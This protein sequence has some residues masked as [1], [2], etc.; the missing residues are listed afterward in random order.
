M[1]KTGKGENRQFE[2]EL[3]H[4]GQ[5]EIFRRKRS[6]PQTKSVRV[7]VFEGGTTSGSKKHSVSVTVLCQVL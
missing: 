7:F 1:L 4:L 2:T 6:E 5:P 3:E